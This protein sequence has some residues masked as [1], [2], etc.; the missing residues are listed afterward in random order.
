MALCAFWRGVLRC[1]SSVDLLID[2]G[3]VGF[4]LLCGFL[5]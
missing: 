1:C 4:C 5:Y 2:G 3:I